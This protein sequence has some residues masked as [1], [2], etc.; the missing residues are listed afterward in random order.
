V[1]SLFALLAFLFFNI[2]A[3]ATATVLR[4]SMRIVSALCGLIGL[5]FTALMIMGDGGNPA[6]FWV[7]GHGGT[8]RMIAYPVMLWF[9]LLGGYL[10]AGVRQDP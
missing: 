1:H 2:E 8:E 4:G 5:V 9:T 3:L 10:I 7:I 6:A